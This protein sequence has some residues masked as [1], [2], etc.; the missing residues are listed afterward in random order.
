MFLNRSTEVKRILMLNE[1]P[2]FISFSYSAIA[3]I[4][5]DLYQKFWFCASTDLASLS[6]AI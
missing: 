3:S 5:Y 4:S 1:I 2:F 6:S